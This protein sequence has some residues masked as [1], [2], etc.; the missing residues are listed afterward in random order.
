MQ[1]T[2]PPPRSLFKKFT[3][4][5]KLEIDHVIFSGTS[6][7]QGDGV[8]TGYGGQE[9]QEFEGEYVPNSGEI[10]RYCNRN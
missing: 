2:T 3:I 8:M 7:Y 10:D 9:G 1:A 5:N 6:P 4:G